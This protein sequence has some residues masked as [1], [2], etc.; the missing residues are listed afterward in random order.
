MNAWILDIYPDY[1]RN[2]MVIW[3]KNEKGKSI[4][5]T[6]TFTPSFYV[7]GTKHKINEL[8]KDLFPFQSICS[9]SYDE[10]K[11]QLDG[12]IPKNLIRIGVSEYS[13]L[14][15]IAKKINELGELHH[16]TLFNVDIDLALHYLY[17]KKIAPMLLLSVEKTINGLKYI[18]LEDP[19]KVH[20]QYPKI[21]KVYF[22]VEV[23]KYGGITKFDSPIESITLIS[24][25]GTLIL[26]GD[27]T[28]ILTDFIAT[29]NNLDPDVI[30]TDKGDSTD[31]PYLYYR[32]NINELNKAFKLD[33]ELYSYKTWENREGQTYFTYGRVVYKP[34]SYAL[35]GRVHL[36]RSQFLFRE[37]GIQGLVDLS[38]FAGI[39]LQM[40]SRM[41]PGNAIT[42]MQLRYAIEQDVLV[43]WKIQSPEYFKTA[44]KLL[45][46]DHGGYI[47]DPDVGIH[48]NVTELDFSSMYPNIMVNYNISP[49]TV[50]CKCCKN[51]KQKVPVLGYNICEKRIGLVPKVLKP[52]IKRRFKYKK[53]MK[54][55]SSNKKEVYRQRQSILKWLLITSF[56]YQGYRNARFGRIESHEAICAYGRDLL[57]TAKEIAEYFDFEVLHGLID[58]LWIKRNANIEDL[59]E[60]CKIISLKVGIDI[61]IEGC[62]RW[63]VFLPNRRNGAGALNRYYGIFKN[64][65]LKVRGVEMRMKNTPL[66]I[67]RFQE[68]ALMKLAEAKSIDEFYTILPRTFKILKKYTEQLKTDRISPETLI[69]K[70]TASKDITDYRVNN[71][72]Y[73]AMLQ[74]KKKGLKVHPGQQIQYIV[75]DHKSQNYQNKIKVAKTYE[76]GDKYDIEFYT[77]HLI[78][79]LESL[80]LPFGYTEG[81]LECIMKG[82]EQSS[83]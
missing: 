72:S 33:R 57:L 11:Q 55:T 8:L 19:T 75:T 63:I 65:K 66:I 76:A 38:R 68:D 48:D 26:E 29:I 36:D 21:R 81:K 46:S 49:E 31:I 13:K 3:L 83:F 77:K 30:Y 35:K 74:L 40:L 27:E 12:T 62:Y 45:L 32:A 39:P 34:P 67:T 16:Y 4:R 44:W 24:A 51:T 37:S 82:H 79:S 15:R 53:L 59:E 7:S 60:L 71:F 9:I 18:P 52:I 14:H 22:K 41:S 6:D 56:G 2:E 61:N 17:D 47:F 10:K 20:Y 23:E 78:K 54:N 42:S 58:S 25:D 50:L 43:P 1:N 73:A 69:Y 5:V 70:V 80:L 64:G 28:S